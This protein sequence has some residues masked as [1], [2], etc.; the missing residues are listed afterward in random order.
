[1]SGHC[2][3]TNDCGAHEQKRNVAPR[4][5]SYIDKGVELKVLERTVFLHLLKKLD[6]HFRRWSNQNLSASTLFGIGDGLET[7]GEY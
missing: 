1:M 5:M 7:I 2:S 3:S 6:H 4:Q